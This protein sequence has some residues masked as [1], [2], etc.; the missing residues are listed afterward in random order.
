MGQLLVLADDDLRAAALPEEIV[1]AMEEAFRIYSA[2]KYQ[3]PQRLHLELG[4]NVLL[5]MPSAAAGSLGTKLVTLFPGNADR[6]LPLLH[7]LMVLTDGQTGI[8]LALLN[9]PVLTALRTGAVGALSLRYLCDSQMQRLGIVGAG[10]QGFYQACMAA[11]VRPLTDLFIYDS[12]PAK[13]T[14]FIQ[15]LNLLRPDI[16]C[17]AAAFVEDVLVNSQAVITAT[18]SRIRSCPSGRIFCGASITWR[19]VLTNLGHGNCLKA[20]FRSW[21]RS[22]WIRNT[23]WKRRET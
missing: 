23:P 21:T 14:E 18:T 22:L 19:S 15:K 3:M 10:T 17:H 20:C 5:L 11:V 9:G 2:G 4:E 6:G 12:Q 13:I 16:R 1:A 8:P 7:G